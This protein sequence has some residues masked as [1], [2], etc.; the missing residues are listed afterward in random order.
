[1]S[2]TYTYQDCE[3]TTPGVI[4][5]E[6]YENK[7]R[8][9]LSELVFKILLNVYKTSTMNN[10]HRVIINKVKIMEIA[11]YCLKYLFYGLKFVQQNTSFSDEIQ[12]TIHITWTHTVYKN[13]DSNL[14]TQIIFIR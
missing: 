4:D 13:I 9:V 1:M 8:F 6:E 5:P 10:H 7:I 12:G 2:K 3:K 11:I 14:W